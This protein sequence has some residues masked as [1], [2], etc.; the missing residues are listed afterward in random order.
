MK[1]NLL[2]LLLLEH[3]SLDATSKWLRGLF[4]MERKGVQ[5]RVSAIIESRGR[6]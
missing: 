6:L 4:S 5:P 3:P 1:L 2:W